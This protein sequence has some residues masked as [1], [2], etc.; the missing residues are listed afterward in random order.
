[1]SDW[2]VPGLVEEYK[3]GRVSRRAFVT[4]LLG[5]GVSMPL[6]A[7]ILAAC[8]SDSDSGS[9]STSTGSGSTGAAPATQSAAAQQAR[10]GDTFT[11][12]KRGGGGT[13]K[14]FWWQAPSILNPHLSSG[15][16]DRDGSRVAL[17]PLAYFDGEAKLQ[18]QLAAEIPSIENGGLD[19]GNRF[20][21]WKLKRGVTWHDGRPFT[22]DD[23]VFTWQYVTDPATAAATIGSYREIDSCEK[24]D[25]YTVK[26]NFK[27]PTLEWS[28]PFV[29]SA[30]MI[31]PKH[32]HE[33]FKGKEARNAPANLKPVGTGPYK[34]TEFRVDDQILAD[35]NDKY[36]IENRPFFD[37][38]EMKGGGDAVGAARAVMQSG[39]Y[40]YA[41]NMQVDAT[42]LKQ[43]E[44]EP[45]GIL[46]VDPGSGVEHANFNYTDPNVETDGQK[47]SIKNPHPFFTDKKVREAFSLAID[48]K[49]MAEQLYGQGGS[50]A[51]YYAV[52]PKEILGNTQ[53]KLDA[54]RANQLL[55][56]AG[57]RKGGDGVRTKDGKRMKIVYQTSVNK[58][59]QDVQQVVK[60]NLEAIGVEVELK[61]VNST[62]FFG[63]DPANPDNFWHF[64]ADMQM[65]QY[66]RSGPSDFLSSTW[67]TWL[68]SEIAQKENGWALSNKSRYSNPE[69]DRLYAELQ[70]ETDATKAAELIRKGNQLLV[71]DFA[72]VPL[73]HRNDVSAVKKNLKGYS[74]TPW[75]S[76]LFRLAY[77]YRE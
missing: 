45:N 12:T 27:A 50:V 18:P 1:M 53:W 69:F 37:K 6:I 66:T 60:Q 21:T 23:V 43:L 40:D 47:A 42:V 57:W 14:V 35:I 71:D 25:D 9:G 65:Y 62:I 73:I 31:L 68:T 2:T 15:T 38:F 34:V 24:V 26:V 28:A 48:R 72:V 70:K 52:V 63:S 58:L 7:S 75:D 22:A 39:E 17:E 32:I 77:W 11:P 55:D 8:G 56:E 3:A 44:K 33:P 76:D 5:V 10:T 61:A 74:S 30:G 41:W 29:G 19:R 36:Y 4:K 46:F 67:K 54:A 64:Y 16:K 51:N 13:L 59:R 20:V 49:V